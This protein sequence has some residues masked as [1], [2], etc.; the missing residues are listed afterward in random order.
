MDGPRNGG[1]YLPDCIM[2]SELEKSRY[3][4]FLLHYMLLYLNSPRQKAEMEYISERSTAL[5]KIFG[6]KRDEETG[7]RKILK[8]RCV[9]VRSLKILL[10]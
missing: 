1:I 6:N 7:G 3:E 4:F 10:K 8:F 9:A 5:R 2:I